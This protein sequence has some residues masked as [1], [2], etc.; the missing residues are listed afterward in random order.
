VLALLEERNMHVVAE[1]T[2]ALHQLV[3]A[4]RAELDTLVSAPGSTEVQRRASGASCNFVPEWGCLLI[5]LEVLADLSARMEGNDG[6][7]SG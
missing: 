5:R 1:R 3:V 7:W 6:G 4:A 2:I